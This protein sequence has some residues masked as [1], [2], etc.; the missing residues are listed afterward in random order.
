[1]ELVTVSKY[2]LYLGV[3]IFLIFTIAAITYKYFYSPAINYAYDRVS[4]IISSEIAHMISE[5]I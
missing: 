3:T 4:G 5:I 2:M 1:M